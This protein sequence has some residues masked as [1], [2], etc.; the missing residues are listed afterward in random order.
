[1]IPAAFESREALM[2]AIGDRI[3]V[4]STR[5][6]WREGVV[7]AVAGA[8]LRI[9][10][11]SGQESTLVPAPGSLTVLGR[12]KRSR[13][14]TTQANKPAAAHSKSARPKKA[15]GSARTAP[16]PSSVHAGASAKPTGANA[17]AKKASDKVSGEAAP[18]KKGKKRAA[19]RKK[20]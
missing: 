7:T 17:G 3:R 18:S 20:R 11:A 16:K 8:M 10:W 12:A 5:A 2:V 6:P 13:A 4:E 9:H 1:V 14:R 15:G 19:D